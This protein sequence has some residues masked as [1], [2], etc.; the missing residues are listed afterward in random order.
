MNYQNYLIKIQYPL[1]AQQQWHHAKM[2]YVENNI[3]IVNL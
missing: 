2:S 3:T 1:L